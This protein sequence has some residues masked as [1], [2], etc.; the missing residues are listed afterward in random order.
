METN[1]ILLVGIFIMIAINVCLAIY[2]IYRDTTK[3]SNNF[4]LQIAASAALKKPEIHK[5]PYN[6]LMKIVNSSIDYYTSQNMEVIGL[7]NKTPEEISL[8]IDDLTADVST[9][10]VLSISPA[11]ME[12]I[13][14]YITEEFFNRYIYNSVQALIVLNVEKQKN[15]I[16]SQQRKAQKLEEKSKK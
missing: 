6:E 13:L 14:T 16:A 7:A 8:L 15:K 5:L 10:V 9:R 4:E 12:C 2:T 1:T 3:I 11:V